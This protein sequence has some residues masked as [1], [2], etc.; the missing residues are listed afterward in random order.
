MQFSTGERSN[1]AINKVSNIIDVPENMFAKVEKCAWEE[2]AAYKY[3]FR[4]VLIL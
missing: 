2:V 1:Q 4:F 3:P